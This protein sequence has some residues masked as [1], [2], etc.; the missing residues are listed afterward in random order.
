MLAL[1]LVDARRDFDAP[2]RGGARAQ[3]RK[4]ILVLVA[5]M[6]RAGSVEI[7]QHRLG[8]E[9]GGA[10]GHAGADLAREGLQRLQL[11]LDASVAR[12]QSVERLVRLHTNLPSAPADRACSPACAR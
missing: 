8:G 9:L 11:L 10:A 2:E 12:L 7:T 6:L 5:L 3:Q 1:Q 4:Q